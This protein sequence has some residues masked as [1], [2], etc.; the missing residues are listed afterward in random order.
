MTV[1]IFKQAFSKSRPLKAIISAL[2]AFGVID[3]ENDDI[4]DR[5]L[6]THEICYNKKTHALIELFGDRTLGDKTIKVSLCIIVT[7]INGYNL[8]LKNI[9][10]SELLS[11]KIV[12]NNKN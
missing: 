10:F 4:L 8:C 5:L 1:T 12:K 11:F 6:T 7:R 2:I 3:D 9:Y